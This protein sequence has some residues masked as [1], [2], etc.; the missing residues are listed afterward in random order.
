MTEDLNKIR[1]KN[2]QDRNIWIIKK[3]E[4]KS[5]IILILIYTSSYGPLTNP[6]INPPIIAPKIALKI[7][8][9]VLKS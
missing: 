6:P 9:I 4:I 5:Q 8:P 1:S 7:P 2:H 3:K